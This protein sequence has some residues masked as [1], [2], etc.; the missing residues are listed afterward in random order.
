[1]EFSLLYY[2]NPYGL[3]FVQQEPGLSWAIFFVGEHGKFMDSR[4][5]I[6]T[7]GEWLADSALQNGDYEVPPNGFQ[8]FNQFFARNLKPGARPISRPADNSVVVSPVDGVINWINND[9]K[10]DS[11]MAI[12][13]RMSLSLNQLLDHSPFAGNRDAGRIEGRRWQ[14][15]FR[16]SDI[17]CCREGQYW[18][19]CRFQHLR[20]L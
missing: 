18:L 4:K 11:A 20:V 17:G 8:S 3:K 1:V 14:S 7:I 10:L 19:Q 5:S 9:L 12:K 6:A 13:G 16:K 2:H 15:T